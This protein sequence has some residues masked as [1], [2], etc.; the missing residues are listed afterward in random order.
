MKA[1]QIYPP[2][3]T[4]LY[5]HDNRDDVH[6]SYRYEVRCY[7]DGEVNFA[8]PEIAAAALLEYD[9]MLRAPESEG[10]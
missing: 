10:T 5:I 8:T 6:P 1:P 7:L 4:G 9:A 2:E 3:E